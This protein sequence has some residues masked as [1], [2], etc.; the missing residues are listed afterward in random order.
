MS[1]T[2][3]GSE[4]QAL[5]AAAGNAASP[6]VQRRVVGTSRVDVSADWRWRRDDD[7][8]DRMISAAVISEPSW[9]CISVCVC[10]CVVGQVSSDVLHVWIS[11]SGLYHPDCHMLRDGDPTLLLSPLCGGLLAVIWLTV[12]CH[13][14]WMLHCHSAHCISIWYLYNALLLCTTTSKRSDVTHM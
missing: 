14:C 6:S 7:D 4:F 8:N 12:L 5:A 10:V 11:V 3:Q 1:L 2:W 9:R 13:C